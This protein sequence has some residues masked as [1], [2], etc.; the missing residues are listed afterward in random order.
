MRQPSLAYD[1]VS[2]A[3]LSA[4]PH[5]VVSYVAAVCLESQ[6]ENHQALEH[7]SQA[8]KVA[9]SKHMEPQALSELWA[10]SAQVADKLGLLERFEHALAELFVIDPERGFL[11]S[12]A[13]NLKDR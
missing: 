4:N 9:K 8:I 6:G 13:L 3:L 5:P 10:W 12:Q 11:V 2:L 7:L 1:Q